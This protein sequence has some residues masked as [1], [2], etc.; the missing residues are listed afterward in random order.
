LRGT[1]LTVVGHGRFELA[2]Y[3]AAEAAYR[4]LLSGPL[5]VEPRAAITERLQAAVYRQAE[6]SEASGTVDAAIAHYLRVGDVAPDSELAIQARFDAIAVLETAGRSEAAAELL[7]DFRTRHAGH[8]L[9]AGAPRR[10]ATLYEQTGARDRAA[11]AWVDVA[12]SDA[13]PE[14]RRQALYRA[15][16]LALEGQDAGAALAHF[17]RY[18]EH[19]PQPAD[20]RMEAL[21][22]LDRL[23][24]A[25][26]ATAERRR[27][28]VA[29]IELEREMR[30]TGSTD[31]VLN[32]AA[33]LAAAAQYTLAGE[34]RARFDDL[35]LV[36]PL[37]KSLER[38]QAAL[39]ESLAAFEAAAAYQV[40][41]YVTAS[42]WQI[43]DLYAALARALIESERPPGL[44]SAT[45]DAYALLL[46]EQA[47]PFEE[48]AIALHEINAQ[49]SREGHWDSWIERSFADL[50]HLV[51]A[52]FD[53]P[54]MEVASATADDQASCA[55]RNGL[56]VELRR[57]GDFRGAEAHYLACLAER[58]DYSPAQL[59]LGILYDLYL[60]RPHEALDAYRRYQALVSEPDSR[61]AGW[62]QT[63]ERRAGT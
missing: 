20:L 12:D 23:T 44:D 18:V 8:P 4:A 61:V 49:R 62:M 26:G 2:D 38:K 5:D 34:A 11:A 46:E 59:N 1:A 42:T 35:R 50:R 40:A 31:A 27:W 16:E 25:A 48:Q 37:A 17:S 54:E 7:D 30:T 22:H 6:A 56:A 60:G 33:D 55:A 53:R 3:A 15:G 39:L 9:T 21:D 45:L 13:D 51:P 58:P 10:L 43:G 32:R 47:F 19:Y 24:A 63:L 29:K 28:L 41:E 14:V 52:R 57:Q 36:N